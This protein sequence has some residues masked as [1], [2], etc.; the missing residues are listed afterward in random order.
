MKSNFGSAEVT[1][2][3]PVSSL[4]KPLSFSRVFIFAF[5]KIFLILLQ[6]CSYSTILPKNRP[7]LLYV[8]D[9]VV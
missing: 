7:H 5:Y 6:I 4:S 2:P 9:K 8:S 1:G 3:I